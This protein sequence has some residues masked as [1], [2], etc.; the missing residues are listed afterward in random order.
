MEGLREYHEAVLHIIKLIFFIV[1]GL[2]FHDYLKTKLFGPRPTVK[3]PMA[4][5]AVE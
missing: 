4:D 5:P 1:A 3:V 2:F